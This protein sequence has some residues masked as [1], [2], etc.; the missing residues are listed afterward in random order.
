MRSGKG[1]EAGW[2]PVASLS[3]CG[4]LLEQA[5]PGMKAPGLTSIYT[6]QNSLVGLDV[7]RPLTFSGLW[8]PSSQIPLQISALS[9]R[10][11]LSD[12]GSV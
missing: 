6:V 4:T 5:S 11:F 1:R 7:R 3:A 12:E 2:I 8:V 10:A 9:L